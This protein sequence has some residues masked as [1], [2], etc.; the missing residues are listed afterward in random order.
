MNFIKMDKADLNS[1]RL[2]L[3]VGGLEF[4]LRSPFRFAGKLFFVC[5]QWGSNPAI[6]DEE[7]YDES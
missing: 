3:L 7:V 2:E 5:V 1:P 4:I 6:D